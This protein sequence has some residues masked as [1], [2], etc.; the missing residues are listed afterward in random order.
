MNR[1]KLFLF[2][3]FLLLCFS[4][5]AQSNE[6][7]DLVTTIGTL[8]DDMPGSSGDDYIAP[9]NTQLGIWETCLLNLIQRKYADAEVIANQ[10]DYELIRFTDNDNNLPYYI[11]KS[12][13]TSDNLW[14]TYVFNPRACQANLVVQAPHPRNDSNTG[15]QGIYILK[16]IGALFYMVA[17]THRCNSD[18][19]SECAGTT[20]TCDNA[21]ES[22]RE[23]DMAHIDHSIFH[24]TTEILWSQLADPYFIQ[25]H[26]FS[27]KT[28]DPYLIL[29]NGTTTVPPIDYLSLLGTALVDIDP[30]LT[31]K[32]A[33]ITPSI[34]LKGT[35]NMQGRL[36]NG[37]ANPCATAAS[38]NS[39]RF[40]HIEQERSR[41]RAN[42]TGWQKLADALK[43]VFRNLDLTTNTLHLNHSN[44]FV[45][46]IDGCPPVQAL[47]AIYPLVLQLPSTKTQSLDMA[48]NPF[49]EKTTIS[50]QLDSPQK[51]RLEVFNAAGQLVEKLVS[52]M[53]QA[54]DFYDYS[55]STSDDFGV[56]YFVVLTT[57]EG[58]LV[59]KV[60][61]IR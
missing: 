22:Y 32:V 49:L 28:T 48:P 43:V 26:G 31:Y 8:I 45:A 50:Y 17:G 37:S 55:F 30:I 11:L 10:L 18:S 24:K 46:Q 21:S 38:R 12:Q 41:L 19:Y 3:S 52:D 36:I 54:A 42:A 4:L 44:L 20:S 29:S 53:P 25:L 6:S 5:S 23:S 47:Q 33:H 34:R 58:V 14:G 51:V 57:K 39:G 9:S 16:E 7:G 1:L 60:I 13:T 56:F 61:S 59:E 15:D 35:T 40:L 2:H 27:K